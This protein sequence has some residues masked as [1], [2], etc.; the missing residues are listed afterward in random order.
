MKIVSIIKF[1]SY[2]G[3]LRVTVECNWWLKTYLKVLSRY[4]WFLPDWNVLIFQ[5]GR[6]LKK[7]SIVLQYVHCL[8]CKTFE[9][10]IREF[11]HICQISLSNMNV[12]YKSEVKTV[13]I[14]RLKS[15]YSLLGAKFFEIIVIDWSFESSSCTMNNF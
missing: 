14:Y 13:S 4:K 10:E 9:A 8:L 15:H 3:L 1:K 6:R 7:V 12:K 5:I 2:Y 11:F